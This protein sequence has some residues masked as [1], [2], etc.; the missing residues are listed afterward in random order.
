VR[1]LFK[2]VFGI[3]LLLA[4]ALQFTNPAHTNPP[5]LPGHDLFA[6]NSPPAPIAAL[7]KRS[8]YDCHSYESRWPWYSYVAPFSWS[9]V[10][11]VND[12]R[13][14]LNF[15]EWPHDDPG[16]ARKK[17]G[18]AADAVDSGEMPLPQYLWFHHEARLDAQQRRQLTTWAEQEAERLAKSP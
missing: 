2:W 6:T 9:L 12:A 11:H 7:L 15:S 18:R 3:G 17:W 13:E 1:R 4:I 8:C 16:R 14:R 10:G 5:V